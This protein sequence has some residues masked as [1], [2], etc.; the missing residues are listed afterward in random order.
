LCLAQIKNYLSEKNKKELRFKGRQA[1]LSSHQARRRLRRPYL[2]RHLQK[3][4]TYRSFF[5]NLIFVL[6]KGLVFKYFCNG[7]NISITI[8][9]CQKERFKIMFYFIFI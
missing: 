6:K 2:R 7:I 4:Q 9:Y 1:H 3:Q 5:I 8:K